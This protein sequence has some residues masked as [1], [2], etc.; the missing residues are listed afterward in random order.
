MKIVFNRRRYGLNRDIQEDRELIKKG[1][2]GVPVDSLE[3]RSH[4]DVITHAK[5][6]PDL[7][8]ISEVPDEEYI[9]DHVI[10]GIANNR[11]SHEIVMT[12]ISKREISVDQLSI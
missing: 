5:N 1:P 12:Y 7:Y 4:P 8:R 3:F 11:D 6:H 9:I 10:P 2:S